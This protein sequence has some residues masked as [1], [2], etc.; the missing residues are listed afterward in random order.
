MKCTAGTKSGSPCGWDAG[1]SGLCLAHDPARGE[2]RRAKAR[3]ARSE[4][5]AHQRAARREQRMRSMSLRTVDDIFAVLERTAVRVENS[6]GDAVAR[7]KA[8]TDIV[9]VA[10]ELLKD[11]VLS[12]ENAELRKIIAERHPDM[13]RRLKLV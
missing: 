1:P 4:G 12:K 11:D 9:R 7:A 13:A 2:E 3:A 10:R 6:H 8:L 5:I